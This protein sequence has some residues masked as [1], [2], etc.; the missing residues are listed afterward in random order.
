MALLG[1][2]LLQ[3][4]L[5]LV[6]CFNYY[7][8]PVSGQGRPVFA[9]D[10]AGNPGLK[11]FRFCNPRL[12][13]ATRVTDLV[14]RLTLEEKIGWLVSGARGVARFGIPNYEWWSE[15]LH[16]VSS[17]GPGTRFANPVPGA[18]S[19]PQVILTAATFN[20]SLFRTIGKVC[21][22]VLILIPWLR[23]GS[24]FSRVVLAC[25]SSQP[26]QGQCTMWVYQG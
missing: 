11:Q 13:V 5:C 14:S 8:R 16:G 21:L 2:F 15:A 6:G 20:E 7:Y 19:F 24:V 1:R 23:I 18:T 22:S 9:C 10:V 26:R 12:D 3:C 17:T 4:F 25:R